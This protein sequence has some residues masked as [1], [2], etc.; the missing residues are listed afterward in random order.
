MTFKGLALLA[1]LMASLVACD[2]EHID[3]SN[4]TRLMPDLSGIRTNLAFTCA[5][6]KDAIPDRDPEADQLYKHARWLQ[7][8]NRLKQDPLVLPELERLYR[9]AVAYGHD[10]ANLELRDMI[11]RGDAYSDNPRKEVIDLTEDLIKR[12]IPGGFYD[13]AYYLETGYGVK[14]DKEL[15]R[16]YQRKAAD[17]GNPEAQYAIGDK[18]T[19]F[20]DPELRKIGETMWRCAA[21]QGH[22]VAAQE[23][24]IWLSNG[25]YT[26]ALQAFQLG[27]KAGDGL[28]AFALQKGFNGPKPDDRIDYLGQQKDEERVRRYKAIWS[29]LADYD[30]LHPKVPEIDQIVPLPPA[31]LP[32]WNGKLKWVEQRKLNFEPPLPSKERIA[33][34]ADAKGLNPMTGRPFLTRHK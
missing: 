8:N 10:K 21:E 13:M 11:I 2:D 31:K 33:E 25:R 7:K 26:E 6:E 24:G 4:Q 20:D 18:L 34:M 3:A 32:P 14:Q 17:L 23:L 22:G 19:G 1:F 9:I 16:K 15:A 5:Y 30:Y 12:G 29:Q 28:S 27:V